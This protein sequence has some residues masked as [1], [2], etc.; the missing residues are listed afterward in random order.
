LGKERDLRARSNERPEGSNT[1]GRGR[2][3]EIPGAG[4]LVKGWETSLE[5]TWKNDCGGGKRE[6]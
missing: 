3:W 4:R 5:G 2:R 6:A 1:R